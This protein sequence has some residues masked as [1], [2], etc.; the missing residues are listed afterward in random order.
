MLILKGSQLF[1]RLGIKFRRWECPTKYYNMIMVGIEQDRERTIEM[2][3]TDNISLIWMTKS[4]TCP[5]PGLSEQK[6]HFCHSNFHIGTALFSH[7]FETVE[8]TD[9]IIDQLTGFWEVNFSIIDVVRL[10]LLWECFTFWIWV[11]GNWRVLRSFLDSEVVW[12]AVDS[13][14]AVFAVEEKSLDAAKIFKW[15]TDN[16]F[17]NPY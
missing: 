3:I 2:G 8:I 15:V 17:L 16:L 6:S 5:F 13:R 12:W 4:P 7:V 9:C 11:E 10:D 1:K 14:L